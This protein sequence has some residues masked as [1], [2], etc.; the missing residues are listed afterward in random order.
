M[1]LNAHVQVFRKAIQANGEKNDATI[2]N[3]FCFTLH[4]AMSE[5]GKNFYERPSNLQI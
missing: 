5:W 3:L 2:I 4:N 1:D